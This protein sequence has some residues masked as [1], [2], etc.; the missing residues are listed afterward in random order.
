MAEN[1]FPVEVAGGVAVLAALEEIDITNAEALRSAL[2]A[3]A[4]S[5]HR[6]LVVDMTRTRFCDSSGL[7]VL[8][9]AH[10]RAGAEG[11]EVLLAIP[12]AAVLRVF[13]LTG[14]DMVIP[15][16][17]S[18]PE[19]L[20]QAAATANGRSRQPDEADAALAG[21]LPATLKRSSEQAQETFTRALAS[22]VQAYGEGDQAFRAAY[23]ELKRTF[24][25]R[26]DHWIPKQAPRLRASARG[27]LAAQPRHR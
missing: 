17:T 26:G 23:A 15:T 27:D 3:A 21:E 20:A 4:A 5:G 11:R 2:L 13:V 12:S 9:A 24:E 16:F 10:K 7:H 6:V 25:K 8:I 18:L 1:S 14:M 22:A 19:A